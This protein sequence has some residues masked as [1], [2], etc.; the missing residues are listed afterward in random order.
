MSDSVYKKEAADYRTNVDD[1]RA[2]DELTVTITL[3]EYL[4]LIHI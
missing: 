3:H 1:F 4:S 2:P